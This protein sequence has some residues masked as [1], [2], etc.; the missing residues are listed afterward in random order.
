MKLRKIH[1]TDYLVT[2]FLFS[3]LLLTGNTVA[4]QAGPGNNRSMDPAKA[5]VVEYWTNE[6]R[7]SAIPRDF[8]I[9]SRGLGYLRRPDG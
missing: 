1:L 6:R 8:V 2:A 7:A 3:L 9:D 4:Q 5:R